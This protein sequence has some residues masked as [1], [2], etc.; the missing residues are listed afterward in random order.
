MIFWWCFWKNS[1]I[2]GD[3]ICKCLLWWQFQPSKYFSFLDVRN[4]VIRQ[5]ISII[6]TIIS[7]TPGIR[8]IWKIST[9]E[10]CFNFTAYF[11]DDILFTLFYDSF[12]LYDISYERFLELKKCCPQNQSKLKWIKWVSRNSGLRASY[13]KLRHI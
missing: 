4:M 5:K 12:Y 7:N 11:S 10:F 13:V 1:L 3:I 9:I 2:C 8:K 6:I